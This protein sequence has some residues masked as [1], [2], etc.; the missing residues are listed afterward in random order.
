[1]LGNWRIP[2]KTLWERGDSAPENADMKIQRGTVRLTFGGGWLPLP[3]IFGADRRMDF[4]RAFSAA[5]WDMIVADAQHNDDNSISVHIRILSEIENGG[6]AVVP[7]VAIVLG[8]AGIVGGILLI[9]LLSKAEA[10]LELPVVWLIAGTVFLSIGIP[11]IK[12]L[13]GP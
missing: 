6:V 8:V 13:R 9:V 1:M 10:I 2:I 7:L 5:G 3:N 4:N 12:K 11:A